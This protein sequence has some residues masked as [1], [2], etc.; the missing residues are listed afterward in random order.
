MLKNIFSALIWWPIIFVLRLI[1]VLVGLPL[2]AVTLLFTRESGKQKPFTQYKGNWQAVHLPRWAWFWDNKRDGA[3]GD[4]RGW[5]WVVGYP[6]WIN[7]CPK[8]FR[9]YL[10]SWWWLSV[11]NPANNFS[12]FTPGIGCDVAEARVTLLAGQSYVADDKGA[13]GWQF[14]SAQGRIFKYWGFYLVS[15]HQVKGKSLVIRLGHKVEPRHNHIVWSEQP[16]KA[17]KGITF[18]IGLKTL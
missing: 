10:K 16:E 12:R 4:K 3:K 8:R 11:R 17:W 15:K 6:R 14:V 13:E 5:Y 1:M 2:V 18:R 9:N 7:G